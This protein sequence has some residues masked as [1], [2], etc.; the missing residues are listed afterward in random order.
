MDLKNLK[1]GVIENVGHD[2]LPERFGTTLSGA[3]FFTVLPFLALEYEMSFLPA[4]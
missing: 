3:I 2:R 4:Q 1:E